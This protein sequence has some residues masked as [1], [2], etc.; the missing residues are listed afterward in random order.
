VRGVLRLSGPLPRPVRIHYRRPPDRE[1]VFHQTLVH[2][3][4]ALV[5]FLG[6]ATLPDPVTVAGNV[7]LDS[8]SPVV[9]FTFPGE[10]HDI[11]RFHRPDGTFTGF[12][13][14]VLTPVRIEG[15]RWDTTDLFLDLFITPAGA[16]HRLDRDELDAAVRAGWVDDAL[17]RRARSEADRLARAALGG[18]WPPPV[19]REWTLARARQA[20]TGTPL[21]PSV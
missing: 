15:D 8:G 13:V 7:V 20:A 3:T 18:S 17:A 19:V 12:Y 6:H 9:W 1:E 14:N 11:G 16:V 4:G 21:P 5:T 10:W 2:E